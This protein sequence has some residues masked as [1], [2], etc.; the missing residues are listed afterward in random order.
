MCSQTNFQPV[1]SDALDASRIPRLDERLRV[2][3]I[4][5]KELAKREARHK[6]SSSKN[7]NQ[8]TGLHTEHWRDLFPD[9]KGSETNSGERAGELFKPCAE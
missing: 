9:S 6:W 8:C 5:S 3:A 2:A 4:E 1:D 7:L